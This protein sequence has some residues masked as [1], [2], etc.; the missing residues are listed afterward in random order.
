MKRENRYTFIKRTARQVILEDYAQA[1]CCGNQRVV[2]DY[3]K[4][5][6]YD[7][8][9]HKRI[10]KIFRR[11]IFWGYLFGDILSANRK[12]EKFA[13]KYNLDIDLIE[14]EYQ[15][16]EVYSRKTNKRIR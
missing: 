11:G 13:L 4:V 16:C 10:C 5:Y 3:Y 15:E 1:L 9:K 14:D 8:K 6:L 12:L 7:N 2:V